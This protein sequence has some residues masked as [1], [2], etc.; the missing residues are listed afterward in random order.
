MS[1]VR[2]FVTG[3]TGFIGGRVARGLRERGDEVVAL[4]RNPAKAGAL[5]ELGCELVEGDLASLDAIRAGI[6][7]ADAVIHGG[8]IY[9]VGIKASERE[10]MFDSNVRGTAR[11]LDAAI[12][13]RIPRIVFISSAV[14]FGH[15]RGEVAREDYRRAERDFASYYEETKYLAHEIA[16]ERIARGAPVIVVQPG[17]V[18]GPDDHSELG[19]MIEQAA[20]GKLKAKMLSEGGFVLVHVQDLADG[21]LLA[22]DRGEVGEAY[23][24]AGDKLTMGELVDKVAVLAGRKPPRVTMPTAMLKASAPLGPVIGPMMGF[25]PNLGELVR[26]GQVTYY[27]DDSKARQ[28]LGY[29]TRPLDEGLRETIDSLQTG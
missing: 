19:T 16:E 5:R 22:L 10:T 7:G 25:P 13:A 6:E 3:A 1:A 20:T 28:D 15:T 11:V 18:Y 17:A 8:A 29:T 26:A 14:V 2:V 21:I 9:Q 27:A 24:L 12:D 23:I 4:V